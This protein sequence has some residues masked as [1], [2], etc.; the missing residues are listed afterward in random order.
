MR[1]QLGALIFI[2]FSAGLTFAQIAGGPGTGQ[3]Q[4]DH[5]DTGPIQAG[6]AVVTPA[7]PSTT[8]IVVTE[9]FGFRSAGEARQAGNATPPLVTSALMFVDVSDRL[10]KNVGV[11]IVNPNNPSADVTLTVRKNDGTLL[12]TKT[13]NIATRRQITQ[14]VT[15]LF[16]KAASGVFSG[17][18][19]LPAEFTGTMLINSNAPISIIGLRFRGVNFSTMPVTPVTL[20]T[21]TFPTIA[22]G[23]GGTGAS[24]LPEFVA[25]G[26][27]ATE[28]VIINNGSTSA[29]VRLDLFKQDGTSLTT[30]LNGVNGTSFTNVNIPAGGVVVFAPR[31]RNGDDDF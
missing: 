25:G 1:R 24:I 15:E 9:T 27:W 3:S 28:I 23:V 7:A 17:D 20:F 26:G 30:A 29:T 10:A 2:L 16:P 8:G 5:D 21:G 11:A 18:S 13:I 22:S 31:N 19:I 12:A 14:F 4:D 6:W